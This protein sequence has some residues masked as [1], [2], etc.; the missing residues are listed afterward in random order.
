MFFQGNLKIKIC[1]LL[2]LWSWIRWWSSNFKPFISLLHYVCVSSLS[3]FISPLSLSLSLFI[4][5][6]SLSLSYQVSLSTKYIYGYFSIFLSLKVYSHWL[7]IL[8]WAEAISAEIHWPVAFPWLFDN[9]SHLIFSVICHPDK[10]CIGPSG[11][12]LCFWTIVF[13]FYLWITKVCSLEF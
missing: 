8:L 5:P 13:I 4:S 2:L 1:P 9:E 3:L 7:Q 11:K 12:V 6:I 10:S